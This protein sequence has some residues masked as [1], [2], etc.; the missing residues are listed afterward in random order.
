[1]SYRSLAHFVQCLESAGELIR[2][3]EFVSPRLEITEV[4]DRMVKAG[5]KALLFENTGTGF[6]LLINAMASDRRICMAL[7]VRDLHEIEESL[8]GLLME[9]QSPKTTFLEKL[10]VLPV[11][12]TVASWMPRTKSGRGACQEVVMDPPDLRKLPVLTCWPF[13]GGPFITLPGVHTRCPQTGTR[14]LGMY[15]MQVF[16]ANLTGMHWHL[17]KGSAKHYQQY[18]EL[19]LKMPVT[20]TLGG[21]PAYIYAATAPLP[22]NLDEYLLAGFLRRKRVELVRCLTN[23]LE[24]PADVDFV[25]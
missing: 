13:D 12:Q 4:A 15:R 24:V 10:K 23:D 6:P 9:F 25:I 3:R 11:L 17:H 19:G 5:G 16:D 8:A 1:M 7:G 2:I 14:N 22:E 21:D 20:V 18:K